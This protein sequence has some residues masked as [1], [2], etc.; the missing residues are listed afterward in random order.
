MNAR[1]SGTGQGGEG[2]P[3]PRPGSRA[4]GARRWPALRETPTADEDVV[5]MATESSL[6]VSVI[7]YLLAGPILFGGIAWFIGRA[8]DLPWLVAVGVLFGLGLS[9]YVIWLR[10]GSAESQP[11]APD[12]GAR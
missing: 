7:S 8:V 2:V 12:D 9:L 6:G 3:E 4:A 5:G 1:T 11:E 10:Y